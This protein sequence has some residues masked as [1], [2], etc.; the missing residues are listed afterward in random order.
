M[1][2]ATTGIAGVS[3]DLLSVTVAAAAWVGIPVQARLEETFLFI[4][5]SSGVSQLPRANRPFL[6]ETSLAMSNFNA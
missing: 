1:L 3:A 5:V 4:A 2:L 6:A